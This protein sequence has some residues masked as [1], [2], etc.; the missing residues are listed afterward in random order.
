MFI[1]FPNRGTLFFNVLTS[2]RLINFWLSKPLNVNILEEI[3][4]L[5]NSFEQ[6]LEDKTTFEI[7][8]FARLL[9]NPNKMP[10]IGIINLLMQQ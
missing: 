8:L 5:S 7:M 1:D 10:H 9:I 6:G 2:L 4:S 3:P